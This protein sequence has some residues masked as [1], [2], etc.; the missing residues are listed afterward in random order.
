MLRFIFK[1][2][3]WGHQWYK[4]VHNSILQNLKQH[5]LDHEVPLRDRNQLTMPIATLKIGE[6]SPQEFWQKYVRTATPVIIKGGAK[7]TYAYQNWTPEM[8]SA[9]VIYLI[10]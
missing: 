9:G 4:R 6:I 5:H 1:D 10:L 2:Q 8:F 3:F 7:H